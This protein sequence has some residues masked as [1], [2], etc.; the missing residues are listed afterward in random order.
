MNFT[1]IW[2]L[3]TY[4]FRIFK[5]DRRPEYITNLSNDDELDYFEINEIQKENM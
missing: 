1:N 2:N 5:T 4:F 3:F